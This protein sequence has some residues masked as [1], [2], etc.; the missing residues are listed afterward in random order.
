MT[1]PPEGTDPQPTGRTFTEE[2]LDRLLERERSKLYGKID[3]ASEA[4]K[5]MQAELAELRKAEKTR[6]DAEAQAR[7]EA[8]EASRKAAEAEMSAKEL[9]DRR[10]AELQKQYQEQQDQWASKVQG[11]E[12]QMAER[13]AIFAKERE[14][15]ALANYAAELVNAHRDDIAP[16]L[17]EFVGGNTKEEIDASVQRV[18]EKTSQIL[19]GIQQ[20]QTAARAAM[21]GVSTGG[22]TPTGPMDA[23]GGTRQLSPEDIAGMSMDEFA[24]HRAQFGVAGNNVGQGRFGHLGK[25]LFG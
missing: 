11:L 2:E 13:E 24:A 23:Q 8:E 4:Q 14:F 22:F 5:A 20:A 7:K 12:S 10:T 21:P 3:K 18:V 19:S 25:G 15:Q 1:T 9:I 6:A 17:V 16:E